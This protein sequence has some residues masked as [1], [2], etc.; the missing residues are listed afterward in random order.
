MF[1]LPSNHDFFVLAKFVCQLNPRNVMAI[2]MFFREPVFVLSWKEVTRVPKGFL[3]IS[4]TTCYPCREERGSHGD[5][6]TI[7]TCERMHSFVALS[8]ELN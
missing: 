5:N 6:T 3:A 8:Y 2:F 4:R 7:V 1:G